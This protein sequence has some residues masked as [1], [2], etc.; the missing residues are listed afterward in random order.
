MRDLAAI[1]D[2]CKFEILVPKYKH[3]S[4]KRPP[5]VISNFEIIKIACLES[6]I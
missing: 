3:V 6:V 2:L 4:S 5:I 1:L